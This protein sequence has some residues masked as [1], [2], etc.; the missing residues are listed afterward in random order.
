M[1]KA[2]KTRQY[3][4]EKSAPVFNKRGFA[5]TSLQHLTQATGLTKGS[6]YGNF[7]NK[8]EVAAEVFKHNA[9]QMATLIAAEM[10]KAKTYRAKLLAYADI[11]DRFFTGALPEGGCPILNTSVEADDT[12]EALKNLARKSFLSWK[13]SIAGLVAMGKAQG[14]FSAATD[15][16]AAAITL[17]AFLEGA[18]LIAKLTENESYLKMVTASMRKTINEF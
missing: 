2:E 9:K 15:P 17:L 3:I 5:G 14:E 7:E 1:G 6:I 11:Y 8:D 16:E 13:D 10:A 12:H 18:T 4:I